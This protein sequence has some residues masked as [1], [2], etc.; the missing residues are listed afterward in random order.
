MAT[1][2]ALLV[3]DM[4][5]GNVAQAY[6]RD[7]IV[8]RLAG[9]VA[10]ARGAGTPVVFVQHEDDWPTMRPGGADWQFVP[11]LTPAA[12]ELVINKRA[13][14]SFYGT[15]LRQ[16]LT[17]RG[18]KHLVVTGVMTE[19]CID[20]TCRRA[21]SEGFAVTLVADGHTTEEA[22]DLTAAQII[23]HHNLALKNMAQP[24]HPIRVKPRAEISF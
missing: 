4:Q 11:E 19:L 2:T 5:I 20:A 13:S 10:E 8:G 24:D 18:I 16:E 17:A 22:P 23:A 12:G 1:D 3:I 9:M 6:R 21:T 7:E 14:D 15:P